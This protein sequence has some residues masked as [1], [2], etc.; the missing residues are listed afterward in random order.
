MA[1][2]KDGFWSL[3]PIERTRIVAEKLLM[4]MLKYKVSEDQLAKYTRMD[5]DR[6]HR[7]LA[8]EVVM[9]PIDYIDISSSIPNADE[10]HIPANQKQHYRLLL[11]LRKL[12]YLADGWNGEAS[13]A[14]PERLIRRFQHHINYVNDAHL[15]NWELNATD[16]GKLQM[17]RNDDTLLISW[18]ELRICRGQNNLCVPFTKEN[19]V[20]EME[21]FMDEEFADMDKELYTSEEACELTMKYIKAI[22]DD[23]EV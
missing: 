7:V 17:K 2:L 8:G 3:P 19:F 5:A 9:T 18:D 21:Q 23:A 11:T 12:S 16:D 4:R 13:L 22:Y 10:S 6:L 14:I 1:E 15:A 20:S